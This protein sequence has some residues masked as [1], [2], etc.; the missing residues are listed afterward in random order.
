MGPAKT[1]WGVAKSVKPISVAI[2]RVTRRLAMVGMWRRKGA[3]RDDASSG[4]APGQ[5]S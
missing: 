4:S 2:S 1:S 3:V 5:G